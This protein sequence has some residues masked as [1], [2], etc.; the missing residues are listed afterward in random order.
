MGALAAA[1]DSKRQSKKKVDHC[2]AQL[3][4]KSI[5]AAMGIVVGMYGV[6]SRRSGRYYIQGE[7]VPTGVARIGYARGSSSTITALTPATCHAL[8][9]VL[10]T[11]ECLPQ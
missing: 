1:V 4:C 11:Q 7:Q 5:G 3:Y 8:L 2:H 10:A 9:A 6:R